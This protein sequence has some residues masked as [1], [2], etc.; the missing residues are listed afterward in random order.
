MAE[1]LSPFLS[2]LLRC[3]GYSFAPSQSSFH[4]SLRCLKYGGRGNEVQVAGLHRKI[5]VPQTQS[6]L[7]S[8][9]QKKDTKEI[10]IPPFCSTYVQLCLNASSAGVIVFQ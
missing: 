3:A 10:Q 7:L 2:T 9:G 8:A 5:L 1:L 4:F 6:L